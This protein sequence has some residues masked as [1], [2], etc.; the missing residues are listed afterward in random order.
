MIPALHSVTG[1]IV[2]TSCNGKDLEG[3]L[4]IMSSFV[5]IIL[6]CFSDIHV[7]SLVWQMEY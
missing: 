1:R 4:N 5:D 6:R 7:Q 2:S 3:R